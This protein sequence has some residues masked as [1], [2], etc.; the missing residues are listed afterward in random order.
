M[1]EK[2]RVLLWLFNCDDDFMI[3]EI[4]NK[5]GIAEF[6]HYPGDQTTYITANKDFIVKNSQYFCIHF[7]KNKDNSI[8]YYDKQD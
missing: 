7:H 6:T 5:F 4:D 8:A 3:E 1:I 2:I